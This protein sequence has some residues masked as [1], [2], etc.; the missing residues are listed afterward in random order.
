MGALGAG[1]GPCEAPWTDLPCPAFPTCHR[2][3]SFV[4]LQ[5]PSLKSMHFPDMPLAL[6]ADPNQW[7]MLRDVENKKMP[8]KPPYIAINLLNKVTRMNKEGKKDTIR[9]FSR[10]S[11]IIPAMIGHT[12]AV[13]NGRDF[14]P[15]V[16][17]DGMVCTFVL[18]KALC[19][20]LRAKLCVQSSRKLQRLSYREVDFSVNELTARGMG[21]VVDICKRSRR[22]Q[23]L[24]LYRN[25]ISDDCVEHFADLLRACPG[26]REVHLSH[27]LLSH[28]G[29]LQLAACVERRAEPLWLRVEQ[30]TFTEPGQPV[31]CLRV[32]PRQ[33][34][35][36]YNL[37]DSGEGVGLSLA[38]RVR[39]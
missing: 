32:L 14:V 18:C 38:D 20:A 8:R 16:I 13:H 31:A 2:S 26:L 3:W 4:G 11:T 5:A 39:R 17:N 9:V 24:K 34:Y 37:L 23:V 30:N 15:I 27:N 22:L 33:T 36:P 7:T 29:V 19:K 1:G 25:R 6:K 35:R 28:E 21:A 12:C 10:Q